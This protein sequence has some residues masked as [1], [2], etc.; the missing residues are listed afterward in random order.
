MPYEAAGVFRHRNGKFDGGS[1]RNDARQARAEGV[2]AVSVSPHCSA[3]MNDRFMSHR[4]SAGRDGRMVAFHDWTVDCRTQ[5]HGAVRKLSLAELKKLAE[6]HPGLT[7]ASVQLAQVDVY[8]YGYWVYDTDYDYYYWFTADVVIV[9]NT[10]I[11]Y[12]A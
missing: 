2:G 9:D 6:A 5:G 4:A 3:H 8:Y 7:L 10:W 12:V 1:L 11:E